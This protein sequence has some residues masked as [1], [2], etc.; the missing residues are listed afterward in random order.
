MSARTIN[1]LL[2]RGFPISSPGGSPSAT[3]PGRT[4]DPAGLYGE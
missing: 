4:A 1:S 3:A 2:P